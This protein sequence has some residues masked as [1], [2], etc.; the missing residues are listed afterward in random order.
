ME[1]RRVGYGDYP[2]KVE[3]KNLV[4]RVGCL[5]P[6]IEGV[7]LPGASPQRSH[8]I[9]RTCI[10]KNPEDP[11]SKDIIYKVLDKS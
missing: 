1:H 7:H 10:P 11:N 4:H 2:F 6:E 8:W 5:P 3:L 9:I